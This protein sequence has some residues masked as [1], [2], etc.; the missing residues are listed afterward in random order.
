VTTISAG[1]VFERCSRCRKVVQ[2]NKLFGGLHFCVSD[3]EMAGKHLAV[4]EEIR[5]SLWWKR[6]W[7][8]CDRCHREEPATENTGD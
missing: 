8:V 7:L 1:K 2:M 6:T 4:R 5:G 3:C